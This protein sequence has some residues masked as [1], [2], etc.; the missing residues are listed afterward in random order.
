MKITQR[1]K[2]L[3]QLTRLLAFN[4]YLVQEGDGLTLID[5]NLSGSGKGILKAAQ[6]IGLPIT[7]VTLT[8]AHGDHAGSLDEVCQQL[9]EVEI[10][11]TGR[12][13]DFLQGNLS[14]EADEPQTELRGSFVIRTTQPTRLW[15]PGTCQ[16]R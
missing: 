5:T 4:C 12:T 6:A 15:P 3:W 2:H 13:A 8:H 9:S 14:L 10:A 1:G 16:Q 7:R 11:F